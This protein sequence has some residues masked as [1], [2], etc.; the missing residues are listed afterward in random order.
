[1]DTASIEITPRAREKLISLGAG[2]ERFIR[3]QVVSGGCSGMSC[4]ARIDSELNGRDVV[5]YEDS[6]IR[7]V[8]DPRSMLYL[9]RVCIDYED[10]LIRAGFRI[11]NPNA[12]GSWLRRQLHSAGRLAL[13]ERRGERMSAEV[14]P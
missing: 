9:D 12:A 14:E 8:S 10:D 7:V 1:M 2:G 13:L 11:S 4:E 6:G 3:L 5:A